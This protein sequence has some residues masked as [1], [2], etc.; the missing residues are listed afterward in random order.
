MLLDF[1]YIL[2][3]LLASPFVLW[4]MATKARVRAGLWERLGLK[5]AR[6]AG[7]RPCIWVHGVS[8][9]EVLAA[10]PLIREIERELPGFEVA[11]STTTNMGREVAEKHYPGKHVLYYPLDLSFAVR[12]ALHAVRPDMIVLVEL[13]IWPNFL[14]EAYRE[15][16]PVAL[17]NGRISERSFRGYRLVKKLLFRPLAKI[18]RFCVQTVE[19]GARFRALGIAAEQILVTGTLKYD[20]LPSVEDAAT[21]EKEHRAALGL[22]DAPVLVCGST[23]AP[24]ER[25]IL[26]AYQRLKADFPDL[27]L[28]LVP[29]HVERIEEVLRDVREAGAKVIRKTE[30]APAAVG[31]HCGAPLQSATQAEDPV[32]VV[33]TMGEL[34]K[35]YAA[36]T[37]VFVGGS[38]VDHGGQN[39]LEPAGLGRATIFGPHVENF[40]ESAD[41]LLRAGGAAQVADAAE[42]ERVVRDLLRDPAR[43]ADMGRCAWAAIDAHRGAAAKTV[44]VLKEVLAGDAGV[45]FPVMPARPAVVG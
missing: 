39:M 23:H 29:R 16:I 8:V 14:R 27:R 12:R 9:G 15:G 38:L 25:E 26:G 41:L 3:L 13:E 33:D 30:L 11:I 1:F 40:R 2:L 18:R 44:A 24:E 31:A 35:I 32:I 37:V 4:K 45:D 10:K 19:Y 28:V 34:A 42:L 43:R 20:G 36:A 7:D 17:V 6:R 5:A 22:G 21:L